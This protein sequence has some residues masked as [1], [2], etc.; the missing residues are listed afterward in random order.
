MGEKQPEYY[1]VRTIQ[2][3]ACSLVQLLHCDNCMGACNM[4]H[5]HWYNY[6][7][8]ITVWEHATCSILTGTATIHCDNCM[9]AVCNFCCHFYSNRVCTSQDKSYPMH[10]VWKTLWLNIHLEK[11][12]ST[13]PAMGSLY[14]LQGQLVASLEL[15]RER[16]NRCCMVTHQHQ[17]HV[18][19]IK[20]QGEYLSCQ[21]TRYT[22]P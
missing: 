4:Q 14:S 21:F 8:V 10:Q 17:T 9:G 16:E 22:I 2:H 13:L 6:Y 11:D 15:Q 5:T 1:E 18:I 3:A 12:T 20:S 19:H 7:T